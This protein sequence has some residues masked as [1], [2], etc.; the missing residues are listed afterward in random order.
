MSLAR[1]SPVL[2]FFAPEVFEIG[3]IAGMRTGIKRKVLTPGASFLADLSPVPRT[4][5][6]GPGAAAALTAQGLPLPALLQSAPYAGEGAVVGLEREQ[7]LVIAPRRGAET[8]QAW[9]SS[10]DC[11]VLDYECLEAALGGPAVASLF[12]ELCPIDLAQFA[13]DAWI[14]TLLA[15]CEVFLRR[16]THSRG[17][18]FRLCCSPAEAGYLFG[19]LYRLV[20]EQAGVLLGFND[21]LTAYPVDEERP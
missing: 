13:P 14:P 1:V 4:L 5:L 17:A 15:G 19:L 11:L 18:H 16:V 10:A 6:A 3:E 9:T 12:A 2:R 8:A 7:F 21:Y 20:Q